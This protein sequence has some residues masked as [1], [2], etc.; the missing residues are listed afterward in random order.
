MSEQPG[1]ADESRTKVDEDDHDLLTFGEAAERLRVEIA[2]LSTQIGELHA[3]GE[4]DAVRAAEARLCA[5]RKAVT[6]NSAGSINDANF[7]RFFG[8]TGRPRRLRSDRP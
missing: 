7:E 2:A 3:A 8:F 1:A 5:L 4:V 6:R